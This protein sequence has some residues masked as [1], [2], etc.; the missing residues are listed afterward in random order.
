MPNLRSTS[1]PCLSLNSH[2]RGQA[3]IE[4]ETCFPKHLARRVHALYFQPVHEEFQL[5]TMWS[6][7]NA[8]TSAVKEM[9]PIPQ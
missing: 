7:S 2:K 9:D 5:R 1:S 4:D 3:F 8:F 6:P